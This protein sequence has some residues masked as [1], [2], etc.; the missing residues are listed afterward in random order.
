M[1]TRA[2]APTVGKDFSTISR[3]RSK[4]LHNATPDSESPDYSVA[5]PDCEDA[6]KSSPIMSD[7]VDSMQIQIIVA[8]I[9]A[10]AAILVPFMQNRFKIDP[11]VSIE[12]DLKIVEQLPKGSD[13]RT[14][15]EQDIE[16]RVRELPRRMNGTRNW[17]VVFM[18]VIV[19]GGCFYLTTLLVIWGWKGSGW[20]KMW[21][22]LASV[23][24][25]FAIA[26]FAQIPSAF[27]KLPRDDKGNVI[28][29]NSDT[30]S[31]SNAP[32]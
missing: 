30:E 10:V 28:P 7:I 12:R 17:I 31:D 20:E 25:V 19:G 22:L 4:V 2:I 5:A 23:A 14:K 16:R 8:L 26:F 9:S 18:G 29:P 21:L 1:G 24:F 32:K 6:S 15:L 11:R 3:D 13:A 27:K